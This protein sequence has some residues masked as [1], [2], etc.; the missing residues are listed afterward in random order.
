MSCFPP[1]WPRAQFK[2]W[3]PCSGCAVAGARPVS[4]SPLPG[5]SQLQNLSVFACR[6]G[7]PWGGVAREDGQ[8][9][10]LCE[11]RGLQGP[12]ESHCGCC[13]ALVQ[14]AAAP[15]ALP[16]FGVVCVAT[17]YS[18][19]PVH[20]LSEGSVCLTWRLPLLASTHHEACLALLG[21][22]L[23]RWAPGQMPRP[24]GTGLNGARGAAGGRCHVDLLPLSVVLVSSFRLP[25]C[26]KLCPP[27]RPG[28]QARGQ[29]RDLSVL[30]WLG[31]SLV[32]FLYHFL[33]CE[34]M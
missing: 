5:D 3:T 32:S 29:G 34:P 31:T 10:V 27:G 16:S 21:W 25:S 11:C 13:Q 33:S 19:A 9:D 28:G 8:V 12:S 2:S 17:E 18:G 1:E 23:L 7:R 15:G 14:E 6:C 22:G 30:P 20:V 4:L 26:F 24:G